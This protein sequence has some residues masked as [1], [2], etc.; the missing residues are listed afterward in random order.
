VVK[1]IVESRGEWRKWLAALAGIGVGWALRP[2]PL[3]VAKLE[4]HQIVVH[5]TARHAQ[6]PLLFGREWSPVT[7][8]AL[9]AFVIPLLLWAAASLVIMV[10]SGGRRFPATPNDRT[11]LWSSLALAGLFFAVT[12]LNTKR[13]TPLWAT[14]AVIVLAMAFTLLFDRARNGEEPFLGRSARLVV[15]CAL[16]GVLGALMWNG[17]RADATHT[18]WLASSRHRP[19]AAAEWLRDNGRP[20][21]IVYNVNWGMFPELFFWNAEDYYVS[22]LDPVFLYAYDPQLYWKFHH[23]AVGMAAAGTYSSLNRSMSAAVDTYQFVRDDLRASYVVLDRRA[24]GSLDRYLQSDP[25]FSLV[26]ED[27]SLA[28]YAVEGVSMSSG[29]LASMADSGNPRI[30]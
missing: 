12:V 10:A 7:L 30:E 6:L 27:Q 20:G 16:A 9:G 15:T 24:Y 28:V 1:G 13:V 8:P 3:G 5:E 23:I 25:R 4:Y 14:C 2:N 22:G 11:F 29:G 21:E 19:K 26:F 18:R 17:L